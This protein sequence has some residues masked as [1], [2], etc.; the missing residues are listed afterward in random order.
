MALT[1]RLVQTAGIAAGAIGFV[2][3]T[4]P[5][6]DV[7]RAARRLAKRLSRDVRYAAGSTHGILYR[8]AG[9]RPD[10]D[11]SNDVLADR[12]RSCLGP[13]EKRLDVPRVHVIVE[14]HVAILHGDVPDRRDADAIER[15]VM[16]ISGV[17]GVESHL[18]AGLVAGDTRPSS[19]AEA[20]A[21]PSDA[22]RTLLA[23]ASGAGAGQNPRAAVHAALCGFA[24]RMPDVERERVFGHLPAD[25]RAMAGPARRH[26]DRPPRLK[27]LP[28]LVAAVT[29]EG[30]I[31]PQHAE[32]ITRAVVATLRGLVHDDAREVAAVLPGELRELWETEPVH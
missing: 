29:A 17:S 10:P 23:A 14:D 20:P 25:V 30:G 32:E 24:D 16:R 4:T 1:K 22:L 15:A 26:R 6:S 7:G 31:E 8:L 21:P 19:G 11:V 13:L 27:T 3:V 12:V 5:D 9:R 18:H 2:A 28:Q